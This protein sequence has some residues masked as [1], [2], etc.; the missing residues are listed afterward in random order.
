VS[1]FQLEINE[2]IIYTHV[3]RSVSWNR[4]L[5]TDKLSFTMRRELD[6]HKEEEELN[7][8]LRSVSGIFGLVF[9]K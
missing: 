8:Q 7:K 3:F 5:S 4:D 2:Q 1:F 6:K 9:F